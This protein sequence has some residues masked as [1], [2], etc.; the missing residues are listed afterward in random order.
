VSIACPLGFTKN[1]A[2]AAD[3]LIFF[4]GQSKPSKPVHTKTKGPELFQGRFMAAPEFLHAGKT[5]TWLKNADTPTSNATNLPRL[6]RAI[7]ALCLDASI[8]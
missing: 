7:N 5:D 3:L 4:D 8:Q 2:W 1:G 6:C